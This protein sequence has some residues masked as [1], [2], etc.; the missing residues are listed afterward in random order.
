M[1]NDH[2]LD[3]DDFRAMDDEIEAYKA[4]AAERERSRREIERRGD[5]FA[6]TNMGD[7]FRNALMRHNRK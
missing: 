6:V 2:Q 1:F 5:R 7:A 4:D 3:E